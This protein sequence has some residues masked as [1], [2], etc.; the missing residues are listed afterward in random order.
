MLDG[1]QMPFLWEVT[2]HEQGEQK[3]KY[4]V[5]I[6]VAKA[7]F[8]CLWLK[9]VNTL[10][11][12]TKVLPNTP[13]GFSALGDWLAQH[14]TPELSEIHVVMEA[15]GIYHEP[16]AYAL[17][18]MGVQVSVVNP[19]FVRDFAKG[20]G[21]RSKTDKKDS[22]VLARYG[23]AT[24]PRLWQ[25]EPVEVRELKALL[26]RLSALEHDLQRETNRLEKAE[27]S[28]AS[29]RVIESI[30][31][32]VKRL[33]DEKSRLENSIDDHFDQHPKLKQDREH[34]MSI[35]AVGQ[36][37]SREM[38]ALLRSRTFAYAGQSAAFIGLVPRQWE[39]GTLKG[40][41]SLCK[42]GSSQL[43]A[44]LYMAAI[45][46]KQYNPDIRAQY[47]RLIQ[48][49]KTKMQAL[50]AAMRKLVQI[51]FGV[52]KHQCEYRSQIAT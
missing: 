41:T 24:Q 37:L 49:G 46:A 11:V 33:Q 14:I 15:T 1:I 20:M 5:G 48:A 40:R 42:N 34:L 12:K 18:E 50:G 16:L 7:K 13:K 43:R 28:R 8:D 22:M 4:T 51:C 27:I 29:D 23:V 35:P 44:K 26:A 9:D 30:Q 52:I 19:A 17:Y 10:K 32:M 21:V 39:S 45:V 38:V 6:D 2:L 25:P 36:V 47:Q 3:M 31:L